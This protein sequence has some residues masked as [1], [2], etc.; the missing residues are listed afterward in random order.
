MCMSDVKK[1]DSLIC[2]NGVHFRTVLTGDSEAYVLCGLQVVAVLIDCRFVHEG[3]LE[4]G[5]SVLSG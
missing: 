1:L 3:E 4:S 5:N 2:Y